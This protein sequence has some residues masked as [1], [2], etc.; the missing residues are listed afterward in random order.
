MEKVSGHLVFN[1]KM[2]FTRKRIWVLDGHKNPD[3]I[4]STYAKVVSREG[5]RISFTFE[6]LNGVNLFVVNIHNAYLK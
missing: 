3:S 6:Y 5:I 2:D 1:V 4:V